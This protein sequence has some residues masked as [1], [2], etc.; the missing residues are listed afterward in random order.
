MAA[1]MVHVGHVPT[2]YRLLGQLTGPSSFAFDRVNPDQ[3]MLIFRSPSV[4]EPTPLEVS[5]IPRNDEQPQPL[6]CTETHPGTPFTVGQLGKALYHDGLWSA[7][8]GDR[9]F[10]VKDTDTWVHWDSS[11]H[12]VTWH[13]ADWTVG[14]RG[15]RTLSAVELSEV[16]KS[17]QIEGP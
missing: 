14:V 4:R 3:V 11:A 2:G 1:A 6:A 12:S 5:A 10:R 17:V 16:L 9:E 13:G 8:R 7:G 15:P